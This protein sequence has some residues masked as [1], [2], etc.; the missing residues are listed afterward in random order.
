MSKVNDGNDFYQ[1]FIILVPVIPRKPDNPHIYSVAFDLNSFLSWVPDFYQRADLKVNLM[2]DKLLQ[3]LKTDGYNVSNKVFVEGFSAGC[4]FAARYVLLHPERVQAIAGGGCA[5]T[6]TLPE[7]EYNGIKMNWPVGINN[8][9]DLVGYE[10]NRSA[11]EQVAQFIYNGMLDDNTIVWPYDW[12]PQDMW[13]S[14]SQLY[15]LNENFGETNSERLENQ[16]NYLH[17]LGY[18]NI[19]FKSYP[20]IGHDQTPEMI[21]DFQVFILEH[22]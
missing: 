14:V 10:F 15:F 12:G 22:R 16:I 13:E 3:E 9:S 6:L 4:L 20:G 11:Y 18:S 7:A 8:L 2:I 5:G 1:E 21:R 19:F 17:N